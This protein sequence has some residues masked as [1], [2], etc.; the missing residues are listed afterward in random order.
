[1]HLLLRTLLRLFLSRR[2]S[3]G[4][5]WGES[6]LPLRVLLTDLD[7][8]RH[9]NNGMYFSLMDLGRF[10][11]MVRSG[12]WDRMRARKWYP[13]VSAE[14]IAFRK[15]LT[16]GQRYS[17]ETRIAGVDDRAIYFEQRMVSGGEI[18]ARAYIA[19]RLV[20]RTGRPISN[21]EIFA[22]VGPPPADL[23]LPEWLHSWR[24]ANALPG[25]NRPAVHSWL[26]SGKPQGR[27]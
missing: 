9:I 22:E 26:V 17:I 18:H 2:R 8:A 14:T 11:L 15:S 3:R 27:R 10:D 24:Q 25:A 21:E 5:L 23:V 6:S 16:L 19:T 1:M 7:V 12:T 4:S 13:V 20:N